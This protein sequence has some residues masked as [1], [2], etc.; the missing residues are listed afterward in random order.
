MS[1]PSQQIAAR[2]QLQLAEDWRLWFDETVGR[3]AA[4]PAQQQAGSFHSPLSIEQLQATCPAEIWPGFMLPDTL[5]LVGNEYGDWIC[6]RVTADNRLGELIHWYHGGGDW[7][8]VG[9]RIGEVFVH[10][11]VDQFR[12][13]SQQMLRGAVESIGPEQRSLAL[14]GLTDEWQL[15]WLANS[16]A[17]SSMSVAAVRDVIHGIFQL[18][19]SD[20][21]PC[22]L[23]ELNVQGWAVDAVAC[24]ELQLVLQ[25]P[26]AGL[27]DPSIASKL[28]MNWTPD[29]VR[30]LFDVNTVPAEIRTRIEA[31]IG[32][33]PDDWPRQRWDRAGELAEQV[34][35]RRHDLGWA[36][37]IAG[38]S[39]QRAGDLLAAA[40]GYF[41]GRSASAFSDQ[42]VRL[43][44]HWSDTRYGKFTLA[45]LDTLQ[46]YLTPE[47]RSD[48][49]LNAVWQAPEKLTMSAVRDFWYGEGQSL[50][51]EGN[52]EQ[53]YSCFYRAGWD[54][55]LQRLSEYQSILERMIPCAQAAGWYARAT[56]AQTHLDCLRK[57]FL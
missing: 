48:P 56:V 5:P 37:N 54:I 52:F 51:S 53:A 38:W 15:D 16:I 35:Q 39:R 42:S 17:S 26:V 10:D 18:L 29:Y 55:G 13:I 28:E 43:R 31:L 7:I 46:E 12:P 22:A 30:W 4:R 34:V 50:Y 6:A 44:T 47:Q 40:Q 3:F 14:R 36:I 2:Y 45:Q 23:A 19:Q 32:C 11:L 27:L 25:A 33:T 20:R 57:R 49:Y 41:A 9:A 24:D 8:P 21:Y 1:Q